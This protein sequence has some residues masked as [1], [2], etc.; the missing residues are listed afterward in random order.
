MYT[1]VMQIG[2]G[3]FTLSF[4]MSSGPK[5]LR[6]RNNPKSHVFCCVVLFSSVILNLGPYSYSITTFSYE[7]RYIYIYI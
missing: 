5:Y 3:K 1:F 7:I 2:I 4:V 6:S